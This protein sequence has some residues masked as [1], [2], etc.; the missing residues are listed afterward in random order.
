MQFLD[1]GCLEI[2]DLDLFPHWILVAGWNL[3]KSGTRVLVF[4]QILIGIC[5][6]GLFPCWSL[7]AGV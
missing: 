7:V 6:L 1:L 3:R 2:C 4:S 5:V